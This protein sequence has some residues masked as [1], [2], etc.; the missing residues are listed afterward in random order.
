MIDH[1][2]AYA[3]ARDVS[4]TTLV[5]AA[6]IRADAAN[7]PLLTASF[8]GVYR[9]MLEGKKEAKSCEEVEK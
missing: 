4:F 8:P 1:H 6:I 2:L 9:A 3:L 5:A 7:R